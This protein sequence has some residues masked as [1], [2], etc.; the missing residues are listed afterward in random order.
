[1]AAY[2]GTV[3]INVVDANNNQDMSSIAN[4]R[5][6][7]VEGNTTNLIGNVIALKRS[8]RTDKPDVYQDGRINIGLVTKDS[9]WKGVIDNAGKTQAG[10]VNVWLSNGAQWT[11]EATSRVDGLDYSHM[12]A[13]SKPS[14]D[15]F[16]GVSYVNNLI[17]GKKAANSGYIYQNSDVKLNIANYSG[18]NT[19]V[20]KHNNKGTVKDD[21]IGGDTTIKHAEGGSNITLATGNNNINLSDGDE[22]AQCS[23]LWQ[24]S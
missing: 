5:L 4:E 2:G 13:Y 11:H 22:V 20:Y 8:E 19:I 23:M 21:F 6:E 17:G 24:A 15:N 1:M 14:Y 9:T 10:E 3:N 12:P 16:D 7:A 18:H